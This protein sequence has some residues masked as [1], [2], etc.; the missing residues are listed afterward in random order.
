MSFDPA[1]V[2]DALAATIIDGF[3]LEK[4]NVYPFPM[5]APAMPC[6]IVTPA[7]PYITYHGSFGPSRVGEIRVTVEVT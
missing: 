6:A 4:L 5:V 1:A 2:H 3:L 7:D